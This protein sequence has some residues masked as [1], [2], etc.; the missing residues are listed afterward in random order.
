MGKVLGVVISIV[1]AAAM[2]WYKRRGAR[3]YLAKVNAGACCLH[4]DSS[5]VTREA[6]GVRCL[7]CGCVTSNELIGTP[8]SEA[9]LRELN[10]VEAKGRRL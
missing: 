9:E 10:E 3:A 1:A 4:C 6:H 7:A 8:V 2:S 5:E